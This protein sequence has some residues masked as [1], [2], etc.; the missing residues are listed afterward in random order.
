MREFWLNTYHSRHQGLKT[1]ET[2]ARLSLI[3]PEQCITKEANLSAYQKYFS[4]AHDPSYLARLEAEAVQE[5]EAICN[6]GSWQAMANGAALCLEAADALANEGKEIFVL[7]RPPGHHAHYD[8]T[9]G[10]CFISNA[11]LTALYLQQ[12][13]G[14]RVAVL[15]F[16][17]HHGD[18]T[19]EI[20]NR[21][22]DPNLLF[23]STYDAENFPYSRFNLDTE[24]KRVNTYHIPLQS[25]IGDASF[26]PTLAKIEHLLKEFSPDVLVISAGFD[27]NWHDSQSGLM[28]SRIKLTKES[29]M[30]LNQ[31]CSQYPSLA[32][33]EG[34]YSPKSIKEGLEAFGLK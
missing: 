18:G 13:H 5:E 24:Q 2:Q 33:L 25:D 8:W 16:D 10:F 15:D 9:H 31:I 6:P 22:E 3:T 28:E 4:L 7:T 1:P 32:I 12:Q 34:G 14:K 29:Y 30:R 11:A 19:E 27:M 26:R 23:I 21:K 17:L 20:L